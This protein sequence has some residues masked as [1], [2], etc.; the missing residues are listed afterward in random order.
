MNIDKDILS[1]ASAMV[2]SKINQQTCCSSY[3]KDEFDDLYEN[4]IDRFAIIGK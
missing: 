4:N 3:M 2:C 1:S